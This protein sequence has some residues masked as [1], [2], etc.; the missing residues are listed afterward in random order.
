MGTFLEQMLIA[1]DGS[2]SS[3]H[4]A[5]FGLALA[6]LTKAK[7]TL[8]AVLPAPE[9][10]PLGPLS[11]Q[12]PL[13]APLT[14]AQAVRLRDVLAEISS[15]KPGLQIERVVEIGPVADTILEQAQKRHAGLIVLGARGLSAPGRFLLG[16][17][18]DRVMHHAHCPVTV[19]R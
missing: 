16:S 7:V 8:L 9:V 2:P 13:G 19:Y 11:G 15:E 14:E 18:S 12:I 6:E 3:L 5:R 4:A 1:V 10:L 17:V